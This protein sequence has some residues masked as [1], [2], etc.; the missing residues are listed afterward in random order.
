MKTPVFF[1]ALLCGILISCG[2]SPLRDRYLVL[3]PSL[4]PPQ[5]DLLGNPWWRLEWYDSEGNRRFMEIRGTEAEV[6]VFSRWPNP[7]LARPFWP[8][9]DLPPGFFYPAGGIFP[10]DVSGGTLA[11]SWKAGPEAV[12]YE[13]LAEAQSLPGA[14]P[15]RHPQFFDWPRFRRL[16]RQEGPEA[17]RTDPWLADWKDA[18][19]K[20]ALSGFKKSMVKAERR[21]PVAVEIPGGGPW[22]ELSPFAEAA[23]WE[24]GTEVSLA[25]SARPVRYVSPGGILT[26]SIHGRVWRPFSTEGD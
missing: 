25:L 24:T 3:L 26:L 7:V 19:V 21:I 10:F 17:L 18:A 14:D 6:S 8:G 20:T 15:H 13:E 16:L 1:A 11:L 23:F 12:F 2:D 22:L 4:P 5:R 9:R